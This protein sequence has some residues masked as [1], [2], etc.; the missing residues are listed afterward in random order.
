MKD[1]TDDGEV[2]IVNGVRIGDNV[3][4]EELLDALYAFCELEKKEYFFFYLLFPFFLFFFSL[5]V[6]SEGNFK[7]RSIIIVCHSVIH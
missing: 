3:E 6:T 4:I 2:D 7:V 1:D 5:F